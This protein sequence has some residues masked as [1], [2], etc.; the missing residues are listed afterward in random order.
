MEPLIDDL[1][2]KQKQKLEKINSTNIFGRNKWLLAGISLVLITLTVVSRLYV[3]L[4]VPKL[5]KLATQFSVPQELSSSAGNA[6]L[7]SPPQT[8]KNFNPEKYIFL[9]TEDWKVYTDP[10]LGFTF[11]YPSNYFLN[12]SN[13]SKNVKSSENSKLVFEL[14]SSQ[15]FDEDQFAV[16]ISGYETDGAKQSMSFLVPDGRLIADLMGNRLGVSI[17]QEF[18]GNPPYGNYAVSI[19]LKEQGGSLLLVWVRTHHEY[20]QRDLQVFNTLLSTFNF[21]GKNN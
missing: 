17:Y 3:Y 14:S 16:V 12:S 2:S 4:N 13:L 19:P 1:I 7:E 9:A 11:K 8:A 18:M 6:R 15:K 20:E 21:L 5:E 10:N